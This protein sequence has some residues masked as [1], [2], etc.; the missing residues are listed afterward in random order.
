M[1]I[2][3]LTTN[4]DSNLPY[5]NG[6]HGYILYKEKWNL[7][8]IT[9]IQPPPTACYEAAIDTEFPHSYA[10]MKWFTLLK[11]SAV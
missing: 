4:D 2:P 1:N 8:R 3:Q 7:R 10:L 9:G 5:V 6:Y 11:N